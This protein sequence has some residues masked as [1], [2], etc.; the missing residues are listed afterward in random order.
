MEFKGTKG[1]WNVMVGGFSRKSRAP[2]MARIYSTNDNLEMVCT[3]QKDVLL[4]NCDQDFIANANLISAAPDLLKVVQDT[5]EFMT[6]RNDGNATN[7]I[8]NRGI[9]AL[10]KA[11]GDHEKISPKKQYL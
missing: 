9:K 1:N 11:L 5:V 8:L 7:D 6:A 4:H 2:N 10:E 3:V